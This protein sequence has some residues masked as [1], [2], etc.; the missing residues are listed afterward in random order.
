MFLM[1]MYDETGLYLDFFDRAI[2]HEGEKYKDLYRDDFMYKSFLRSINNMSK[3][4]LKKLPGEVEKTQQEKIVIME[5]IRFT[6]ELMVHYKRNK[7]IKIPLEMVHVFPEGAEIQAHPVFRG[8]V[9][10]RT[11]SELLNALMAVR[12][13][14]DFVSFKTIMNDKNHKFFLYETGSIF[15]EAVSD[16][17]SR[18]FYDERIVKNNLLRDIVVF[19]GCFSPEKEAVLNKIVEDVFNRSQGIFSREEIFSDTITNIING[20]VSPYIT[21]DKKEFSMQERF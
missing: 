18:R 20:T 3:K 6:E 11:N 10:E 13:I 12:K 7:I 2:L 14:S 1:Q 4:G 19:E 16:F 5:A 17:F 9:V 15:R 8:I 21:L